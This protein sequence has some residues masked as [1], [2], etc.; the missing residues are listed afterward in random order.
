MSESTA[1]NPVLH[2]HPGYQLPQTLDWVY[3]LGLAPPRFAGLS[4]LEQYFAMARG[5]DDIQLALDMSKYFDTNYRKHFA[6]QH[7]TLNPSHSVH[8][9]APCGMRRSAAMWC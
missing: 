1:L 9:D 4:G 7:Q 6:A 2:L 5:T 3:Y 8:M